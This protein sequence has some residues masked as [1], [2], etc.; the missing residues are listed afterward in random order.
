MKKLPQ[1]LTEEEITKIA[2]AIFTAEFP[3]LVLEEVI[4]DIKFHWA[5][6]IED[7]TTDGPGF[8]GTLYVIV[9]AIPT[10]VTTLEKQ[11]DG[12]FTIHYLHD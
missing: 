7:Y 6:K 9:W 2:D 10:C 4:A 3:D 8:V 5:Y 1:P 11:K 12:T